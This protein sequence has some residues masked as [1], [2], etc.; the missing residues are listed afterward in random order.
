MKIFLYVDRYVPGTSYV[1]M[2]VNYKDS[3]KITNTT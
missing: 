2:K 1:I 3:G